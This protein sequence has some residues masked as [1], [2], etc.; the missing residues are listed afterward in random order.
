[1]KRI[2]YPRRTSSELTVLKNSYKSI[3]S[4]AE[5]VAMQTAW[6]NWKIRN[7]VTTIPETIEQLLCSDI[8]SLVDIFERFITLPIPSK[9][10]GP[11]GKNVRSVEYKELDK[12]FNYQNKYA[13]RIAKFFCEHSNDFGLCSCHYCELAYVNTYIRMNGKTAKIHQHF[14][15]DHYLP[16]NLCPI[17]GLSLFNFVPSC[18]VCNSRIKLSK[19][20]GTTKTE[21]IKFSPISET[22]SFNNNV[23]IQ[24]RMHK[25]PNTSFRKKGEYYIHFRCKNGFRTFVDFFHLEERYEFHKLEAIRI[26]Q[27]KAKYPRS[28]RKKIAYLLGCSEAKVKEDLFHEQY[29]NDNNRCFAKLTSDMLK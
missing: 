28:A 3:Y 11:D 29:L 12:I 2:K 6:D 7:H 15:V 9:I 4:N 27:L 21:W 26:K 10:V 22:Y 1:M 18:Q 5:I 24:L 14:D 23:K 19:L 8:N 16:K 20:L 13:S 17:T 25:G